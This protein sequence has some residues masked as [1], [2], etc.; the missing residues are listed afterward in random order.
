MTGHGALDRLLEGNER[1]LE[2]KG[3]ISSS[4]YDRDHLVDSQNPFAAILC[5]SDSRVP[6]E[7]IF[8]VS[9]GEIFVVRVAGHVIASSVLGSLEY[10]VDHLHVPLILVMGHESCG[11]V[12]AALEGGAHGAVG[13]LVELI[14]PSIRS[15]D[16][17]SDG[18]DKIMDAA[19]RE[20]ISY[21]VSRLADLSESIGAR[22][23][24]SDLMVAGAF[25]SLRTGTVNIL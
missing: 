17:G 9:L 4:K 12:R 19:V 2:A 15:L 8:D 11:A 16:T 22:V 10:A 21:S 24:S 20:N 7:H 25:Y 23:R 6:P 18:V 3:R 5:C 13:R 1:F 14:E